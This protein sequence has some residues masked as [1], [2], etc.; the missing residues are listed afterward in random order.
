M[1]SSARR[2][3]QPPR[4]LGRCGP[5]H[6]AG[7]HARASSCAPTIDPGSFAQVISQPP[8][9]FSG[10]RIWAGADGRSIFRYIPGSSTRCKGPMRIVVFTHSLVSDWNHGNAHFLRGIARELAS[11]GHELHILEPRDGWSLQNL[12]AN[13]GAAAVEDFHRAF[14][15]L[16]STPYDLEALNLARELD[17]ADLVLVHEWNS[18]ELVRRCGQYRARHGNL[19]LLFHDTHHRSVT[20]RAAMQ[21]Y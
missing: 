9:S 1:C 20:D 6:S 3:S 18:H 12:I 8:C 19:T 21:R 13:H 15:D 7:R 14:P 2:H 17:A 11:R 16:R 5:V 4:N 10:A